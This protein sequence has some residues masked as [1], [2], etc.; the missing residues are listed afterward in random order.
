LAPVA[1]TGIYG[2]TKAGIELLTKLWEDEY[3]AKGRRVNAAARSPTLTLGTTGKTDE[4]VEALGQTTALHR[5]AQAE[6]IANVVTFLASPLSSYVNGSVYEVGRRHRWSIGR[7]GVQLLTEPNR[8]GVPDAW[9]RSEG[10]A[11]RL[12]A[13]RTDSILL[14]RQSSSTGAARSAIRQQVPR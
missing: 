6:E 8:Q 5:T 1:A 13:I 12:S 11:P 9:R 4:K 7:C 10:S 2:A 14:R 3:G